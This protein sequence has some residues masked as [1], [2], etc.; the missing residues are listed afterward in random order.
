ME[1]FNFTKKTIKN[2]RSPMKLK[3]FLSFDTFSKVKNLNVFM[4][5]KKYSLCQILLVI[6]ENRNKKNDF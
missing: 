1:H 5:I 2:F 3:N 4:K 6:L